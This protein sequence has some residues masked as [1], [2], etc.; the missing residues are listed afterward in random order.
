MKATLS[1]SDNRRATSP[2]SVDLEFEPAS[3]DPTQTLYLIPTW[4]KPQGI[5]HLVYE[6]PTIYDGHAG[7][8]FAVEMADSLL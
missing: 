5:S 2:N 7:N 1:S 6:S 3:N 4:V 8:W